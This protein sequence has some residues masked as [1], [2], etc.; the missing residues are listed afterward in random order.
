VLGVARKER[1]GY[2]NRQHLLLFR[3]VFFPFLLVVVDDVLVAVR[4]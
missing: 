2:R 4:S 3:L 1:F